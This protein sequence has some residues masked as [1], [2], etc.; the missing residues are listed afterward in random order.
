MKLPR[1][2]WCPRCGTMYYIKPG[3][4]DCL[5]ICEC[6]NI[7]GFALRH[8]ARC[9]W[10]FEIRPREDAEVAA[11]RDRYNNRGGKRKP[12]ADPEEIKRTGGQDDD[13]A[14]ETGRGPGAEPG[15]L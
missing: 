9:G 12:G 2:H 7:A 4:R 11:I 5:D 15:G 3:T 1:R 14:G 13:Y 6:I 8:C 10:V